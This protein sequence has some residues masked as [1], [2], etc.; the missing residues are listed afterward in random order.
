MAKYNITHTCGHTERVDIIGHYTQ[1]EKRIEYLES[2]PCFDCIRAEQAAAAKAAAAQVQES[3]LQLVALT[4][5]PKQ[6]AWA[7]TIRGNTFA[8]IEAERQEFERVGQING[9]SLDELRSSP[10]AA[11][12][13]RTRQ[14]LAGKADARFWIDNREVSAR[15]WCRTYGMEVAA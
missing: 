14:V 9:H 2:K 3:G 12:I 11:Q 13:E 15:T 7:E 5:S 8:A 10:T 6:I 1:R 4:G